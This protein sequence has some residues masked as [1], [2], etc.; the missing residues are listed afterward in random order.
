MALIRCRLRRIDPHVGA[1][2]PQGDGIRFALSPAMR[3]ISTSALLLATTA[4]LT[5]A[6][7]GC[8]LT[9]DEGE[10][11]DA[12]SDPAA[13]QAAEDL[14]P[15]DTKADGNRPVYKLTTK[16]VRGGYSNNGE[17]C[18]GGFDACSGAWLQ[19]DGRKLI[20]TFGDGEFEADVWAKNGV[21]LFSTKDA[22]SGNADRCDDPGC[23][24]VLKITGV[25]YPVRSGSTW[26]PQLKA[27]YQT[28]FAHPES[29]ED[30]NGE[31]REVVRM[32]FDQ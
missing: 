25:I 2:W 7:A 15:S 30:P 16:S 10:P 29:D 12:A 31:Y 8:A 19:I 1:K 3:I 27:T 14:V 5:S 9:N 26:K 20:V 22:L 18:T 13:E 32:D 6:F 23:G 11:E 17:I 21:L 4:A 28:Q 24:N